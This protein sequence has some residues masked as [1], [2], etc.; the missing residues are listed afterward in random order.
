MERLNFPSKINCVNLSHRLIDENVEHFKFTHSVCQWWCRHIDLYIAF[1]AI[2]SVVSKCILYFDQLYLIHLFMY[3][4]YD[5]T[6][7][8]WNSTNPL[9]MNEN[10]CM[11]VYFKLR[12]STPTIT[13]NFV[14]QTNCR[15]NVDDTQKAL[16]TRNEMRI[17]R[18]C[19]GKSAVTL[20]CYTRLQRPK[21]YWQLYGCLQMKT[22]QQRSKMKTTTAAA[23]KITIPKS[24]ILQSQK[25][26]KISYPSGEWESNLKYS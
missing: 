12:R 8:A 18:K 22:T 5:S 6:C 9:C 24:H 19:V 15:R 1:I 2:C 25:I 14:M 21:L 7:F 13:I 16:K 11:C 23:T 17:S 10:G 20:V 3:I 4:N 26:K